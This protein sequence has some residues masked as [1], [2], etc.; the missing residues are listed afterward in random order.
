LLA[1][2][3]FGDEERDVL[4][5]FTMRNYIKTRRISGKTYYCGLDEKTRKLLL[6]GMKKLV[7]SAS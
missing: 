1:D 4:K 2:D 6:R 7:D 3:Q 5:K